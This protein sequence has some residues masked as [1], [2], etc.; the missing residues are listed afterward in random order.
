MTT[1]TMKRVRQAAPEPALAEA[2][3]LQVQRA[4]LRWLDF[5]QEYYDRKGALVLGI[6]AGLLAVWGFFASRASPLWLDELLGLVAARTPTASDLLSALRSGVDFNPPLYHF[7]EHLSIGMLGYSPAAARLPAFLGMLIFFLCLFRFVSR[8][9]SP[10]YGVL[11]V[12]IVLDTPVRQY[13]WEA[14]P[15][16]LVLGLTGLAM[17]AYQ[18]RIERN[19]G[20]LALAL[21]S[22]A[23]GGLVASHYYAFLII[24]AFLCAEL[25]RTLSRKKIDWL[26]LAGSVFPPTLVLFLLRDTIRGQL[27]SLGQYHSPG[28]ITSFIYGYELYTI[29]T[30]IWCVAAIAVVLVT[31]LKAA[32]PDSEEED[33]SATSTFSGP[34]L[35]LASVLLLLPLIGNA[36]A[37]ALHAYVARYFIAAAAGYGILAAYVAAYLSKRC[38]PVPLLLSLI[39][40]ASLAAQ[41][42]PALRSKST[43]ALTGLKQLQNSQI[44]IVFEGEGDFLQAIELRPDMQKQFY[45]V[46]EPK[47]ALKLIGT[48]TEDRIMKAVAARRSVQV[49]TLDSLPRSTDGILVVPSPVGWLVKCL[50]GMN[51]DMQL[52]PFSGLSN[53]QLPIPSI[54]RVRLPQRDA[55]S[56][57]W[58][59]S[60]HAVSPPA[61]VLL[62]R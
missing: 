28:S 55:D 31:Q 61:A 9:L 41:F 37:I 14:R 56:E 26:L 38:T 2:Q 18:L 42:V 12:L 48:D 11:A 24:G 19:S 62:G 45:F 40:G 50:A 51:A 46:S 23:T 6:V 33:V 5:A 32:L 21:Y 22:I 58:C 35:M 1:T 7:L 13:A 16:G 44:P 10:S 52:I 17:V 15:Y 30:W 53:R 59:T 36:A 43:S 3:G 20:W 29:K 47:L 4:L 27:S 25:V 34:E 49:V 39:I 8:R 60:G 54:L 57:P